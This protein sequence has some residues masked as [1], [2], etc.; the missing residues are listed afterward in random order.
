M[1]SATEVVDCCAIPLFKIT[2]PADHAIEILARSYQ[3][4]RAK[5]KKMKFILC[6]AVSITAC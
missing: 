6:V 4:L 3:W 5:Y 2:A 1:S